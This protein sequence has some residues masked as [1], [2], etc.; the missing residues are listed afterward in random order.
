MKA[1]TFARL[2][3]C[4]DLPSLPAVVLEV[5][6]LCRRPDF[7]LQE[8]AT[9]ITLDP[10]LA[11]KLLETVNSPF[12][13]TGRAVTTV[14]HAVVCLGARSVRTIALGF[15]LVGGRKQAAGFDHKTFWR[16]ALLSAVAARAIANS[17]GS[18]F[19]EEAFLGA[20]LQD[21]GMLA[22]SA[23]LKGEY[24]EV[25]GQRSG[26]PRRPRSAGACGSGYR[27]RRGRRVVG[28]EVA[29]AGRAAIG[30]QALPRADTGRD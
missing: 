28:R 20:L 19:W 14:S 18:P 11:T 4:P 12:F 8:L 25:G 17:M 15:A 24:D 22:L 3:R 1:E 27:P 30:G 29:A 6:D 7:E 9:L 21:I 13:G 10:A 23:T 2:D 16:R 5:L 26:L